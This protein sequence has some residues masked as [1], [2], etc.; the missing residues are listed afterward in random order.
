[1]G[2]SW[3]YWLFTVLIN[4]MIGN[5]AELLANA[6]RGRTGV[7]WPAFTVGACISGF[8]LS[9]P[10]AYGADDS[11]YGLI[12]ILAVGLRVATSSILAR[13]F[14]R[15][16]QMQGRIEAVAQTRKELEEDLDFRAAI[17]MSDR[18]KDTLARTDW[19]DARR[20]VEELVGEKIPEMVRLRRELERDRK[21]I[22]AQLSRIPNASPRRKD[23]Q[24]RLSET[25]ARIDALSAQVSDRVSASV[26]ALIELLVIARERQLDDTPESYA[27]TERLLLE[28]REANDALLA[29]RREVSRVDRL[30]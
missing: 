22:S 19:S 13:I 29:A 30:N 16:A 18:L 14:P 6:I 21:D 25:A 10:S 24:A 9:I 11:I 7:N 8:A 4:L 5:T 2:H 28:T 27:R 26:D 20:F 3:I 23:R 1:M 15:H 12:G 17:D